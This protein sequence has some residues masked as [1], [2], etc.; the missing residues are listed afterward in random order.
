MTD[1]AVRDNPARSRFE[2]DTDGETAIAVYSLSDGV[3]AITHTETPEHLRGRGIGGRLIAGVLEA[4][5]ARG[6]KVAPRCRFARAYM[7]AHPEYRD[8]L[9]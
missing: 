4:A 9:T 1:A 3:L 8:L 7:A 6:L 2:L 5:R